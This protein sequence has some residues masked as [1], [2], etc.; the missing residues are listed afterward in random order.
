ME[1]DRYYFRVGIFVIVAVTLFTVTLFSFGGRH[2]D[3]NS[4]VTY[5]IYFQGSVDGISLGT[6]VKL[7]GIQIGTV[8]EIA[9]AV[10]QNDMIRVLVDVIG[11]APVR[12]DTV[13]SLQIQGITGTSI[14][15][16]ENTQNAQ[17]PRITRK[18]TDNYPIIASKPSPLERVSN[19]I[20]DM[21]DQMTKLARQGQ[22]LLDD[23]NIKA[24]HDAMASIDQSAQSLNKIMGGNTNQS[25]QSALAQLNELLAESKLTMREMRMLTKTVRDDPSILIH[26]TKQEGVKVQQ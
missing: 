6:P 20:P 7:K 3:K 5:A 23:D 16:L 15:S 12:S 9:F 17:M 4:L 10:S 13:A 2:Q 19:S 11:S 14:V 22:M 21:I 1:Q 24:F 25:L 18:D 26:G 8:K